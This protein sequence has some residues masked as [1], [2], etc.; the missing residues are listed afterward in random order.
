V[1]SP[2]QRWGAAREALAEAALS[3]DGYVIVERNWRGGGGEIDR[4]AWDGPILCFI[5]VRAR[6]SDAYGLPMETVTR[7]KQ[8]R[9]I[10]AASAYLGRFRGARHPAARFD[11]VSIIDRGQG[12][13]SLTIIRGAFGPGLG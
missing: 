4:I 5:E 2:S 12:K 10:R 9:I 13:P 7:A 8:R 1:P 11:V 3:R 6:S